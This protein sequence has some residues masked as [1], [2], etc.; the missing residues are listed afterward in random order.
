M[1]KSKWLLLAVLVLTAVLLSA[2]LAS[3]GDGN[4]DPGATTTTAAS[5]TATPTTTA[6]TTTAAPTFKATFK[7][8]GQT[9]AEITFT[10]GDEAL[11]GVPAVPAKAGY[12]GEW[13]SYTITARN[14]TV[15]AVYTSLT[16]GSTGIVYE[17]NEAGTAYTVV[18]YTGKNKNLV[19]PATYKTAEDAAP[20][21]VTAI[22]PNA[23]WGRSLEGLYLGATSIKEIGAH[24][25]A[26][27]AQLAEVVFPV[28]LT[29]VG[30]YAFFGCEALSAVVL[31]NTVT[32]IGERSFADCFAMETL[33]LSSTLRSIGKGAFSDCHALT[34]LTVPASV[35]SL[36]SLSFFGCTSL[37]TLVLPDAMNLRDLTVF[38]GCTAVETLTSSVTSVAAVPHDSLTTLT[39]TAG[40]SLTEKVLD[41]C[42]KLRTLTLG[43]GVT[44]IADGAF[45]ACASLET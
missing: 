18:G 14:F 9:V 16:T 34:A 7:A 37:T 24:A 29:T 32:A 36:G 38:F 5:T 28:T 25:F 1:R 13:A 39:I 26:A 10:K 17:K 4:D 12:V 35:T 42:A 40:G 30:D 45:K 6:A 23:L 8:D 41:G 11:A 43:N 2:T 21:P 3:C 44:Y 31:P 19:I 20:L 22:G 33:T 27:C 15:E